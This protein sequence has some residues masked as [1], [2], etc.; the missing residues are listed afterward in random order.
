MKFYKK[1]IK[2]GNLTGNSGLCLA[3]S[4]EGFDYDIIDDYFITQSDL[5]NPDFRLSGYYCAGQQCFID[6]EFTPLRQNVVLLMACL[7]R[8]KIK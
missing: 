7:N 8:E 3:F 2:Q 4:Q 1:M 6:G 5:N